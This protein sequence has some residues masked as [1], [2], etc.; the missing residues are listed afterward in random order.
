VGVKDNRV[1]DK[2]MGGNA[3]RDGTESVSAAIRRNA[4]TP[5]CQF[6]CRAEVL[7]YLYR[8]RFR[9]RRETGGGALLSGRHFVSMLT[10]WKTIQ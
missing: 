3:A 9:G 10:K 7:E 4:S 6:V 1:G 5:G 8:P 2:T